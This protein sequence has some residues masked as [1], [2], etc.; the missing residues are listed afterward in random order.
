MV[1]ASYNYGVVLCEQYFGTMTGT[2][3]VDNVD[4]SF[5]QVDGDIAGEHSDIITFWL[6]VL[7]KN[8]FHAQKAK[9]NKKVVCRTL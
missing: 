9:I 2:K 7:C 4:I 8:P 5:E 1:G 3:M 6:F